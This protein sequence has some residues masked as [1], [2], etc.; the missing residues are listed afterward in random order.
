[1]APNCREIG[2][3]WSCRAAGVLRDWFIRIFC[4][5]VGSAVCKKGSRILKKVNWDILEADCSSCRNNKALDKPQDSN[6]WTN[7]PQD[8]SKFCYKASDNFA[9][10]CGIRFISL[11]FGIKYQNMNSEAENKNTKLS[12]GYFL[13]RHRHGWLSRVEIAL[14]PFTA[15]SLAASI[16]KELD[17]NE[18]CGS[19]RILYV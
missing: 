9:L 6:P 14:D 15:T 10:F 3:C 13:K 4:G 7:K 16:I 19:R 2:K 11:H 8:S 1:M 12:C 17:L 18:L 5:V